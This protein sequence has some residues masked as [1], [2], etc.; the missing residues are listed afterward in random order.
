MAINRRRAGEL[1]FAAGISTGSRIVI[2]ASG[3]PLEPPSGSSK[4]RQKTRI[5]QIRS[6]PGHPSIGD[7]SE[8]LPRLGQDG[9]DRPT[10][11]SFIEILEDLAG[12]PGGN[13]LRDAVDEGTVG[14]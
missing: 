1:F 2:D 8:T 10:D 7:G 6:S 14:W 13:I 9:F 3:I 11:S 12:Q 5:V 4:D